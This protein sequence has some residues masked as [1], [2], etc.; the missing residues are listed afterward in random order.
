MPFQLHECDIHIVCRGTDDASGA[1]G[2]AAAAHDPSRNP[3]RW[4]GNF[5]P[6]KTPGRPAPVTAAL[7][8]QLHTGA[9]R[10][11]RD[12][13]GLSF[14]HSASLRV[15]VLAARALRGRHGALVFERPQPLVARRL[16]ST[17]ADRL[18]DVR[19]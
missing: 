14:L 15:L 17:G 19:E 4:A 16:E 3:P 6:S 2:A 10:V 18:L 12:A 8:T 5:P 9:R 13:S 1:R 11:T 7:A